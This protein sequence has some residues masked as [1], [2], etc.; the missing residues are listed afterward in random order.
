LMISVGFTLVENIRFGSLEFIADPIDSLSLSAKGN[1]SSAIF[2]GMAHSG[3][4]SLCT[5][6]EDST[7]EFNIASSGGR[8]VQVPHS[9][10]PPLNRDGQ[11]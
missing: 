8:E 11:S 4:P 2:M 9:D 3:P 5:I 7:V 10:V 6:L 1:D